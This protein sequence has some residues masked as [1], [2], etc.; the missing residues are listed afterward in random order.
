MHGVIEE[1]RNH[2]SVLSLVCVLVLAGATVVVADEPADAVAGQ[3]NGN[4]PQWNLRDAT[5]DILSLD[6]EQL[7]KTPVIAPS[8]DIPVTSVTKEAGTVGRSA[9][10]IFVITNEM[11]RRS[12]ATSLPEALR[13]APGMDVAQF[14]SNTWAI[15]SRGSDGIIAKKLLVLIDG[16]SVYTPVSSGVYWDVQDVVLEDVERIEVIRGPGG[17]L[18]GANAVNGVINII[19][20]RANDTQGAYVNA[21]GG[22]VVRSSETAR[23]GG[24]IGDDGYYRVYGKYFD[25]S[26]FFDPNQPAVDGWNQGRCGF[27][28]D[29]NLAQDK[30]DTLT[31]QGDHYVGISGLSASHTQTVQPYSVPVEGSVHNTGQNIVAHFQHVTDEDSDWSVLTYFDNFVR[32]NTVLNTERIRTFD[33]ELQ[34]RFPFGERQHITCGAGYRYIASSCPSEDP[35]TASIQPPD[36]H[37]YTAN[38][39]IQDEI[40]LAPD[41]L[42]FILGCKL[43]QNNFTNFEYQPTAR[44]LWTPNRKQTFW[45]AV[46]RAVRTP[47]VT[48]E[49]LFATVAPA[50]GSTV[51]PRIIGNEALRSETLMAYEIGYRTQATDRFS[52]DIATFYN[53]YDDLIGSVAAPPPHLETIP[54]PPHMVLPIPF[55]NSGSAT[56]YGAELST[57]WSITEYWSLAANYTFLRMVTK[58]VPGQANDPGKNPFH[59]VFLRSSWDLSEDVDFD[60]TARYVDCLTSLAVPSYI[61]MDLRLA[62][63]P[64]KH[65]ELALVGQNLLQTYHYEFGPSTETLGNEAT[66]VPRSVYGS[67]TWRY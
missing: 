26:P 2:F 9:A 56:T 38:Q 37:L 54:P 19:T 10:A 41:R 45:G 44:L 52:Y 17:T 7:A 8:M 65:L 53:V 35:F 46:S 58:G 33:T 34:Y 11:I 63:R 50:P 61:T 21:S 49:D 55:A 66:E 57:N 25:R 36:D 39:F 28:A 27:R 60:L 59:Q 40:A 30:S 64:R 42:A 1:S 20:K 43:E 51:F 23:Y 6:I 12:G 15:S 47:A 32:D 29:W 5:K 16:R 18:W 67:V 3:P 22:T 13:M 24:R 14:N 4:L 31:V 62:W 48:E